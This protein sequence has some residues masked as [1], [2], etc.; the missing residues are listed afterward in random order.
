MFAVDGVWQV[1]VNQ[2]SLWSRKGRKLSHRFRIVLMLTL[3]RKHVSHDGPGKSDIDIG[4]CDKDNDLF[5]LHDSEGFEPGENAKFNTVMNFIEE[6]SKRPDLS[7][8]L[9]AI[10]WVTICSE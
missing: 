6:R 2:Q 4:F 5:I 8:R 9:H 3:P 1:L 7:E 10:W